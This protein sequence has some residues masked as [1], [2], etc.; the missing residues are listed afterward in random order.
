MPSDRKLEISDFPDELRRL[1]KAKAA[2]EGK[3]M[4]EV[5]ISLVSGYCE[6]QAREGKE[7]A[8]ATQ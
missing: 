7:P 6:Q 3:T 1:L 2:V 5:V 4:R 8:D